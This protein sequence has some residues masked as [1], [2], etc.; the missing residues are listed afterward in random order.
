M[1]IRKRLEGVSRQVLVRGLSGFLPY[2][3]VN[4]FPKSGGTWLSQMLATALDLPYPRNRMPILKPAIMQGHYCNPTGLK[5]VVVL[6]RDPR[7]V[8]VSWY[9]HCLYGNEFSAPAFKAR[10]RNE[11][12][13]EDVSDVRQN[14]PRFIEF[15][16][17]SP[18]SPRFTWSQ[19]VDTWESRP[20]VVQTRYET[21][22]KGTSDELVRICAAFNRE[23]S[24]EKAR[25]IEEEFSFANQ[26]KR[27]AGSEVKSSHL[28][29]GIAG[30]WINHFSRQAATTL[31]KY[32]G[33]QMLA[34]G[35][36][37]NSGWVEAIPA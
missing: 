34:L 5:N 10:C 19:F 1:I 14:L 9:H 31:W 15:C 23:L 28:R 18:I 17:E 22:L 6:W 24:P 20:G 8:F 12:Q 35:Y 26:A 16:Y 32:A 29:K 33:P 3:V 36:E 2:F 11:L 21:L 25:R 30:D 27:T 7:D 4:E 13:F 37:S